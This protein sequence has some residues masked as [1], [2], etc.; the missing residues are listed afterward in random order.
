MMS[1]GTLVWNKSEVSEKFFITSKIA[2]VSIF[3]G[4]K[5]NFKRDNSEKE[6]FPRIDPF[7]IRQ[8]YGIRKSSN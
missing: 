5:Y 2:Q 4:N 7:Q 8:S 6:S 3:K 1:L